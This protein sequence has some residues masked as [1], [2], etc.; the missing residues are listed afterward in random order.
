ML[1]VRRLELT[2]PGP[3]AAYRALQQAAAA[4]ERL[5]ATGQ[6]APA[7]WVAGA[8]GGWQMARDS[9]L[10]LVGSPRSYY[11]CMYR[12]WWRMGRL[13]QD[14]R[15]WAAQRARRQRKGWSEA[16]GLAALESGGQFR[17]YH[18]GGECERA[19]VRRVVACRCSLA[20]AACAAPA[21]AAAAAAA[22]GATGWRPSL[23]PGQALAPLLPPPPAPHRRRAGVRLHA[24]AAGQPAVA[25]RAAAGQGGPAGAQRAGLPVALVPPRAGPAAARGGPARA[26]GVRPSA[27]RA[28]GAA[29]PAARPR[30]HARAVGRGGRHQPPGG[31]PPGAP[32]RW[33]PRL[34]LRLLLSPL[35]PPP[36][37]AHTL[38]QAP[39]TPP[40]SWPRS[41]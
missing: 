6:G 20:A 17:R 31:A 26:A 41:C 10:A 16:Q 2:A 13:R 9:V 39:P 27:R 12:A 40:P 1:D 4:T 36:P 38:A 23:P 7:E 33:S 19:R 30:R 28:G 8:G 22:P 29:A 21:A 25:A 3:S 32:A 15:F 5:A 37:P 35:D 14:R 11:W 18:L 24:P 34:R